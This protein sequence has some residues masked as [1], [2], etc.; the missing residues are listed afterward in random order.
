MDMPT[1]ESQIFHYRTSKQV[2]GLFPGAHAG[3]MVGTGQLFKKHEPLI[4]RPD[5]KR[6]D[7][8]NSVLDPFEQYKVKVFQQPSQLSLYLIADLSASM[9]YAGSFDKRKMIIDCLN[10]IY[11]SARYSDDRFGFVGCRDAIQPDF[12]MPVSNCSYGR[13]Q[14]IKT[15]LREKPLN[16]TANSLANA[17]QF[18]PNQPALIF[19]CSDFYLPDSVIRQLFQSLNQH[20]IIPLVIW[21]KNEWHQLPNWGSVRLFDHE[22]QTYRSLLLR[23]SL[24]QK[25]ITHFQNR[26][27]KLTTLMRAFGS[28]PLFLDQDFSPQLLT[29]Y[30]QQLAIH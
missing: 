8:R 5:P 11:E 9:N 1:T 18:I 4:A 3:Q 25:L 20:M 10:A 26:Q 28:E 2:Q 6:I 19:I 12:L 29:Q 30:F 14:Q 16:G 22:A 23:P 13:I 17:G 15:Q 27:Q 24:K 21:D 7:L